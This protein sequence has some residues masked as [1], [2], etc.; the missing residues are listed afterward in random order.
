MMKGSPDNLAHR[1]LSLPLNQPLCNKLEPA[2]GFHK[3]QSESEIASSPTKNLHQ[4]KCWE[5]QTE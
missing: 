5:Q 2:H 4:D 1:C 3:K